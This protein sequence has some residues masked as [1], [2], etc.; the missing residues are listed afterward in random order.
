M[1]GAEKEDDAYDE[2]EEVGKNTKKR[3]KRKK[4]KKVIETSSGEDAVEKLKDDKKKEDV[5]DEEEEEE[6]AIA[7]GAT[8]ADEA[9]VTEKIRTRTKELVQELSSKGNKFTLTSITKALTGITQGGFSTVSIKKNKS[10]Y[11]PQSTPHS[12]FSCIGS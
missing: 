5:K 4:K 10:V 3:A 1:V 6:V 11:R 7:T 9:V 2:D 12:S 8:E